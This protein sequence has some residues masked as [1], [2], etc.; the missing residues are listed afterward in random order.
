ME[1]KPKSQ[2]VEETQ[3]PPETER[4]P[5][6]PSLK[7]QSNKISEGKRTRKSKM[8]K[9]PTPKSQIKTRRESNTQTKPLKIQ[10]SEDTPPAEGLKRRTK[11]VAV[12]QEFMNK[13][14]ENTYW[15]KRDRNG[16][17]SEARPEYRD[18]VSI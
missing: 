18:P 4:S 1:E 17:S 14:P 7:L 15:E 3:E 11:M 10:K 12:D 8:E 13:Y 6:P 16:H 2:K 5:V 9:A